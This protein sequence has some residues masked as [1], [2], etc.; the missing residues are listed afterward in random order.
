MD[1]R[2]HRRR[3]AL[4]VDGAV[5]AVPARARRRRSAAACRAY[6]DWIA[7]YCATDP[8]RL[9]GVGHRPARRRD[10]RSRRGSSRRRARARRRDGAPEPSRTAATSA[11]PTYDPLYDALEETGLVLAVHEALGVRRRAHD[12]ARPLRADFAVRHA[13]SHPLEQMA[14]M[15]SL[16]LEG[17]LERHPAIARRVPRV[18]HRVAAVLAGAPRRAPRVDARHRVAR[19]CRSRP[20]STSPASA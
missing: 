14:A 18:G 10:A 1:A 9:A 15:A 17:A 8:R 7:G 2:G 6:N 11:R 20:R 16:M 5:R 4:P 19:A 12:R 3:R 13:C